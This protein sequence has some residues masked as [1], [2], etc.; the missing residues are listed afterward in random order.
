[1]ELVEHRFTVTNQIKIRQNRFLFQIL[2]KQ[3][4]ELS[5]KEIE[6]TKKNIIL[7]FNDYYCLNEI[8]K[9]FELLELYV[10]QN[11]N[12]L[13]KKLL[14]S[15]YCYFTN[16]V[17]DTSVAKRISLI[18]SELTM[19]LTDFGKSA[20]G[21]PPVVEDRHFLFRIGE[22]INQT[23]SVQGAIKLGV[24]K[25]KPVLVIPKKPKISNTGFL[26]YIMETFEVVTNPEQGSHYES[27]LPLSPYSSVFHKFNDELWGC[28]DETRNKLNKILKKENMGPIF[29][30]LK[31][32]TTDIALK[33][34]KKHSFS[35]KEEFVV[36]HCR[37]GGSEY[38]GYQN[39]DRNYDP[40]DFIPAIK[41]IL[42]QGLKVIRIG[43]NRMK[44]M[45]EIKGLLDLSQDDRP[46]EVDI[47]LCAKARFYLGN[48]SGPHSLA[49]YFKTNVALVGLPNWT[50]GYSGIFTA[51]QPMRDTDTRK[52]LN[53]KE[54]AERGILEIESPK[55]LTN[56][57]VM[58][59]RLSSAEILLF[60]KEMFEFM[61]NGQILK[62]NNLLYDRKE[63]FG[64]AGDVY[65]DRSS[66][67]LLE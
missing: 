49:Y 60:V 20:Y 43:N 65:F 3:R 12:F 41:Y 6:F 64:V 28:H 63:F 34:L 11:P 15:L 19:I 17:G 13:T 2:E 61:S 62:E 7:F 26:P 22:F 29:F 8:E 67:E 9:A 24:I 66:L 32:E 50:Y 47:F 23:A 10:S 42:S 57:K 52:N 35:K 56:K 39:D 58:Q 59:V 44:P 21:L 36:F 33:Y 38:D 14:F 16:K 55:P 30:D 5:F 45:E 25:E 31:D 18:Y 54:R 1:M 46:G 27:V 53:F 4:T 37:E 51:L 48:P 40:Y